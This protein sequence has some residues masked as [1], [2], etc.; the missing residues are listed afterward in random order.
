MEKL[1]SLSTTLRDA[2]RLREFAKTALRIDG[3]PWNHETQ[4]KFQILLIQ[5]RIYL[6]P[7]NTQSL[8]GLSEDQVSILQSIESEMS[9]QNAK[10]I[11]ESKN[12]L[13]PPMRG[14]QSISPLKKLGLVKIIDSRVYCTDLCFKFTNEE[15]SLEDL[16]FESLIKYQYPNPMETGYKDWDTKPF[17][18]TLRLIK[19][20]NEITE[21]NNEKS[22]GISKTEFGIFALS[23]KDYRSVDQV[24][25]ELINF[26]REFKSRDEQ[27][28]DY[29]VMNYID[30]Y[31]SNFKNPKKNCFEYTDNM[32][33]YIR[34]TKYIY[35]RGKF[36]N[37]YIDLEPRR[38]IEIDSLLRYDNGSSKNFSLQAWQEYIGSYGSYVLPYEKP[39]ILRDIA[40]EVVE[41]NNLLKSKLDID[42]DYPEFKNTTSELKQQ[43]LEL[44]EERTHLQNLEIKSYYHYNSDRIDEVVENLNSIIA[45]D[46]SKHSKKFS[47]ELEKWTTIALNVINDAINIRSN[48]IVGDDNEPI[49]TAPAG[50]PDIECFYNEFNSVCEVTMLVARDQWFNE[51]QPVMRHLRQFEEV[52]LDKDNYCIFI[53]PRMH[54]DTLNTFLFSN[55]FGY[56]GKKQKIIPMTIRQLSMLMGKVKETLVIGKTFSNGEFKRLLDE[57]LPKDSI[58]TPREW[59]D[60]VEDRIINV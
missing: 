8:N 27:D 53:A 33:R 11:F 44:R 54:D 9:Y 25:K 59:I 26:R 14:R 52:H 46:K 57:C 23:L 3:E 34:L 15:I 41:E 22:V 17:I 58:T 43:I 6:S 5:N 60:L 18:N 12:Y 40:K 24:A 4:M 45:R 2:L 1:W 39:E 31:L 35:I 37:T 49:F 30:S 20:V 16:V 38:M 42:Y 55:K 50:V 32:I 56:E 36:E 48:M 29:F 7:T 13:D 10:S 47:I 21:L 51:G 28:R 19:A